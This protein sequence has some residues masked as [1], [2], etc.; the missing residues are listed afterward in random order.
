VNNLRTYAPKIYDGVVEML[1]LLDAETNQITILDT[2]I[3][4]VKNNQ[5]VSTATEAGVAM[6]EKI[7]NIAADPS[8][9]TLDFRKQRVINR[10]STVESPTAKSFRNQLDV[11]LGK[12]NYELGFVYADYEL[13]LTTHIGERG[14]VDELMKTLIIVVPANMLVIVNNILYGDGDDTFYRAQVLDAF[15]E[16]TL[17]SDFNLTYSAQA[18]EII[19]QAAD[20]SKDYLLSSDVTLTETMQADTKMNSVVDAGTVYEIQ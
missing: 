12:N 1:A 13:D 20:V 4:T 6:F 9:E 8:T 16:Y 5:Y 11:L 17:S 15:M 3:Q 18:T 14:G 19:A 10:F 2:E 7:L